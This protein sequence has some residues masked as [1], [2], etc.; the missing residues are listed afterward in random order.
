[1]TG[2]P[3]DPPKRGFADDRPP[4]GLPERGSPIDRDARTRSWPASAPPTPPLGP[5]P[6]TIPRDYRRTG[7]HPPGAPELIELLRDRLVDY[8]AT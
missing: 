3:P 7:A 4:P 1:M 5:C 2:P 6:A 8:R